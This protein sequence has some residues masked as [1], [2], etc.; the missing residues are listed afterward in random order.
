MASSL[1]IYANGFCKLNCFIFSDRDEDGKPCFSS[2]AKGGCF[3]DKELE[4]SGFTRKDKGI[5][6]TS[7]RYGLACFFW[8]C[9][10]MERERGAIWLSGCVWLPDNHRYC[11]HHTQRK[12]P[13]VLL[14]YERTR[15]ERDGLWLIS[16]GYY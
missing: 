16:I 8:I 14:F 5:K 2:I 7:R 3:L 9:T 15:R 10:C 6:K 4:A 1:V 11:T 12:D 13:W